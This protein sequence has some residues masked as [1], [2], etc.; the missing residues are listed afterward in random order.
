MKAKEKSKSIQSTLFITYFYLLF[1]VLIIFMS[2]FIISE[3]KKIK[4][5]AI[6]LITQNVNTISSYIDEEAKTLNI[7]AQNIAYS[8]LIKERFS[9]YINDTENISS[10]DQYMAY[11]NIK[12]T[13]I[14][15]DMLA[16]IIGPNQPVVQIYLYSLDKGVFGVGLDT[17]TSNS[18]A[19]DYPW[20]T[21]FMS[22]DHYKLLSYDKDERLEDFYSY[23]NGATFISL[24]EMYYNSY[25]IPQGIIEVKNPISFLTNK[26]KNNIVKSY[27][28][29][30]YIFDQDG[31]CIYPSFS[32]SEYSDFFSSNT[33]K[34]N[35][36]NSNDTTIV[37]YD[38]DTYMFYKTSDYTEFTVAIAVKN[39]NLL[40]PIY[41]YIKVNAMILVIIAIATL[42]LSFIAAHIITTPIT[43]IFRQVQ[44]FKLGLSNSNKNVF[45]DIDTHIIEFNTLYSALITMQKK[46]QQSME[47][48]MTL[49]NQ[50]MQSRM[51]ALQSQMNPHFLYN[52][53]ATIQSMADEHMDNEIHLMCQNISSIL[54]YISTDKELLV[55]LKL[56]IKN[57]IDYLQCMKIRY[58]DDLIYEITI[59][60]GMLDIKIP[61]LCLQL[62]VENSI[63]FTTKSVKP[64]WKIEINGTKTK[65][66]W[67][68][69]ISDNGTGFSKSE[70][71]NLN[72]KFDEINNTGLLPTLEI[73][74]MGLMNIYIR[75][76]FLYK[77][78]HIFR[79]SN[80]AKG[81][82]ILTVGGKIDER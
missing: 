57:T 19:K 48:E 47:R 35:L 62:I 66:Y 81:G 9:N 25:N 44:S 58:D 41:E 72:K 36:D 56:E 10:S 26:I 6:R 77:G 32:N 61:K 18:S 49:Q 45:P 23:K 27:D 8:N 2:F 28:E 33:L 34:D 53:L 11:N 4:N 24:Y 46:A 54:R 12:N 73:S 79:L 71:D 40:K 16:A 68:L 51:L 60:D 42:L 82:A 55:P 37:R 75:F 13:K 64:P 5:N 15:T 63:K 65:T 20:Y 14:L 38:K 69:S 39:S 50:E 3:S 29:T 17:T 80:L 59:P 22:S 52:S 67:E 31:N 43:K 76:K 7:V 74:G 70:I 78:S 30:I 1:A 21:S